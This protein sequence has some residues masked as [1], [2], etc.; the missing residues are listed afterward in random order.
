V[1]FLHVALLAYRVSVEKSDIIL[2]CLPLYVTWPFP[3]VAFNILPLFSRFC[4]DYYV[5]GLF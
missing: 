5:V 3:L 2:I 4:F 1:V